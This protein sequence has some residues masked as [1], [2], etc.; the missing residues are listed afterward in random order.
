MR[1]EP[2]LKRLYEQI[3]DQRA[4]LNE[5]QTTLDKLLSD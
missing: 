3:S 2:E 5:K 4:T 1:A